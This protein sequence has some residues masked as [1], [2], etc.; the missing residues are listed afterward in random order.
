MQ[1]FLIEWLQIFEIMT[2]TSGRVNGDVPDKPGQCVKVLRTSSTTFPA[3]ITA[4]I[5][6]ETVCVGPMI[7]PPLGRVGYVATFVANVLCFSA[8]NV[9]PLRDGEVDLAIMLLI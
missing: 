3:D 8:G 4:N 1:N 9:A 5:T 7:P 2:L 6:S